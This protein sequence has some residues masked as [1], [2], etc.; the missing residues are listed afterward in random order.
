MKVVTHQR[1][2]LQRLSVMLQGRLAQSDAKAVRRSQIKEMNRT[3]HKL[4]GNQSNQINDDGYCHAEVTNCSA[5][6]SCPSLQ[7]VPSETEFENF[8]DNDTSDEAVNIHEDIDPN[9][10]TTRDDPISLSRQNSSDI[11]SNGDEMHP[12]GIVSHE[13]TSL[14]HD[15]DGSQKETEIEEKL[16][17]DISI[18][19]DQLL[20]VYN[21]ELSEDN[22]IDLQDTSNGHS[23]NRT[24]SPHRESRHKVASPKSSLPCFSKRSQSLN[25]ASSRNRH[26]SSIKSSSRSRSRVV[27]FNLPNQDSDSGEDNSHRLPRQMR[28]RSRQSIRKRGYDGHDFLTPPEVPLVTQAALQETK[29]QTMEDQSLLYR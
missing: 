13:S 18:E 12:L 1:L 14:T 23:G 27:N 8:L 9:T 5:E 28:S 3:P 15:V 17:T 29:E 4:N 22:I 10:I 11:I 25:R 6:R 24:H 7:V 16:F 2:F 20:L 21:N 19:N 26:F